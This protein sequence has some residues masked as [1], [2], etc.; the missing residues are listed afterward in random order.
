VCPL[1]FAVNQNQLWR[2]VTLPEQPVRGCLALGGSKAV[3]FGQER[4]L[5][6]IW[7]GVVTAVGIWMIAIG[8]WKI[9]D[10]LE[11]ATLVRLVSDGD[12]RPIK[13]SVVDSV[14]VRV[15]TSRPD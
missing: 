7:V 10:A 15:R 8:A 11:K 6:N 13:V 12:D 5:M 1:L 2:N 9:A 3:G 14:G 4:I